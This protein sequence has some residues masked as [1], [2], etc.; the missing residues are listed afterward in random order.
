MKPLVNSLSDKSSVPEVLTKTLQPGSGVDLNEVLSS[1]LENYCTAQPN[2]CIFRF[3]NLPFVIGTKEHFTRLFNALIF[4]ITSHPPINSKLFLY[5]KCTEQKW[6]NEI[7]DLGVSTG[8]TLY[9]IDLYTNITTDEN[10]E[11]LYHSSLEEC[12]LLTAQNNGSF[13]F[14]PISNTGCLFSVLLPGK[15]N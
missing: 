11:T 13:S 5:V 3:D 2:N 10:W 1:V 7:I 6:D 8:K 14:Y 4:M 12:T 15:I 9:K